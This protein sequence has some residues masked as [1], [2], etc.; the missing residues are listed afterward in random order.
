MHFSVLC[1]FIITW[2]TL[3]LFGGATFNIISDRKLQKQ[4]KEFSFILHPDSQIITGLPYLFY[5]SVSPSPYSH[6]HRLFSSWTLCRWIA[7]FVPFYPEVHQCIFSNDRSI[8]HITRVQRSKPGNWTLTQDCCLIS[9]T[10]TSPVS[11]NPV[12][13]GFFSPPVPFLCVPWL[14]PL[15]TYRPGDRLL[16]CVA[17]GPLVP[18]FTSV[19]LVVTPQQCRPPL[20]TWGQLVL[21]LWVFLWSLSAPDFSA[22]RFSPL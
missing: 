6:A 22:G 14:W 17:G 8:L 20:C 10:H 12:F 16:S 11:H 18:G 7:Y 9:R 13:C 4:C 19:S 5:D 3:S 15:G 1:D 21:L 2:V